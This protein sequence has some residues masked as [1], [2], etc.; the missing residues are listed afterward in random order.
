M[1]L[2]DVKAGKRAQMDVTIGD[3][4]FVVRSASLHIYSLASCLSTWLFYRLSNLLIG[5]GLLV[6]VL[7]GWHAGWM[8]GCQPGSFINNDVLTT[9]RIGHVCCRDL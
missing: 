7:A 8:A 3:S 2:Y 6:V 4:A 9:H 5:A 1:R